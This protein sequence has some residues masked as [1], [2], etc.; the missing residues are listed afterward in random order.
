MLNVHLLRYVK[1]MH[2]EINVHVQSNVPLTD[3]KVRLQRFMYTVSKVKMYRV[4]C[5]L[6]KMYVQKL[7]MLQFTE[8]NVHLQRC[9]MYT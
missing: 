6:T 8:L 9:T 5:T 7:T 3:L 2:T 1:G 4:E